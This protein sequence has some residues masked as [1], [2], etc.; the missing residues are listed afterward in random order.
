MLGKP[1]AVMVNRG[2]H[3]REGGREAAATIGLPVVGEDPNDL[4]VTDGGNA[5]VGMGHPVTK[6]YAL[7]PC[8]CSRYAANPAP[9]ERNTVSELI[10]IPQNL[11]VAAQRIADTSGRPLA[12]ITRM[13]TT[14]REDQPQLSVYDVNGNLT[15]FTKPTNQV[16]S[17]PFG[18]R[19]RGL[20]RRRGF[21]TELDPRP[22]TPTSVIGFTLVVSDMVVS[23]KFYRET[24]GLPVLRHDD[25]ISFDAGSIIFRIQPEKF[26]GQVKQQREQRLL[27]DQLI[28]YAREI[29]KEVNFLS[30]RGV[31][32]GGGI[33][34][35]VSAGFVAYF[36]DPDGHNLW[37]WEPPT[38]FTPDMPINYFPVLD[39]ILRDYG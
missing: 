17:G 27:K 24:L 15:T 39:R 21:D 29:K 23:E 11:D 26:L 35:S 37:L 18:D 34:G 30:D 33:E 6:E 4:L 10:V 2:V 20:M 22:D 36:Q 14:A 32:F 5:L 25:K 38:K 7:D 19:L 16:I 31:V 9:I 12:D 8:C 3:T 1:M 13:I 28:F